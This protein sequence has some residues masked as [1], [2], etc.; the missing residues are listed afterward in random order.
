M[1]QQDAV[2]Q[3]LQIDNPERQRDMIVKKV[4][5][6]ITAVKKDFEPYTDIKELIEKSIKEEKLRGSKLK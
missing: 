2:K 5:E 1:Q 4:V 6:T 3:I